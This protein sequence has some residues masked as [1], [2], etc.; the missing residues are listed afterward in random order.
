ML[1]LIYLNWVVN[2]EGKI[3]PKLK[4]ASRSHFPVSGDF[5]DNVWQI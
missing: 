5:V 2:Q 1:S 4:Y 3:S